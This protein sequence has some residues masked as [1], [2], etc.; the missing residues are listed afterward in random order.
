MRQKL[1][2]DRI[3]RQGVALANDKLADAGEAQLP[4]S[5][6]CPFTLDEIL[7]EALDLDAARSRAADTLKAASRPA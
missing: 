4:S 1:D 7:S 2:L 3:W 6:A 5:L